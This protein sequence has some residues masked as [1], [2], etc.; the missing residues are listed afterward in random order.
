MTS[1]AI[2]GP[3]PSR[4]QFRYNENDQRCIALKKQIRTEL[5]R[6]CEQGVHVYYIGGALGVDMWCAE[7][8]LE[9]RGEQYPDTHIITAIPFE[10]YDQEWKP[11]YKVRM[12]FIRKHTENVVVCAE[13]ISD[14]YR[15]R[16]FYMVD[17]ADCL[18]AVYD[19]NHPIPRSGTAMTVRY[20]Q[21]KKLP[22][23]FVQP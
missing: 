12:A 10:G 21:K 22:I 16:N 19:I 17:H 15:K 3:R 2:T 11:E 13:P 20:A 4:F 5:I 9:L 1:C 8:L 14:S 7:I 6:L 23:L 18:L